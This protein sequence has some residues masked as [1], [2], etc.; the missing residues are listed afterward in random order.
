MYFSTGIELVLPNSKKHM[1]GR[2]IDLT[3]SFLI[4]SQNNPV[5]SKGQSVFFKG[6]SGFVP[7]KKEDRQLGWTDKLFPAVGESG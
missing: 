1:F 2:L 3:K 5:L 7:K 4:D 6:Q